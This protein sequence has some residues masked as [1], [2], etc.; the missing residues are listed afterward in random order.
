MTQL[1][2]DGFTYDPPV[3]SLQLVNP[4]ITDFIINHNDDI[5]IKIIISNFNI[6][7]LII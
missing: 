3:I 7:E 6:I 1:I 5:K 2:V 4:P